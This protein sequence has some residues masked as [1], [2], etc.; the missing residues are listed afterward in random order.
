MSMGHAKPFCENRLEQV[1]PAGVGRSVRVALLKTAAVVV[2]FGTVTGAFEPNLNTRTISDAVAL[3]LTRI[4]QDRNRF[5]RLYRIEV[6]T[7]PVDWVDIITPFRR[8]VLEA[9]TQTQ[10]GSRLFGQR[11]AIEALKPNPEQVDIVVELT[12]HP[13]NRFTRIPAYEVVVAT[14]P[15]ATASTVVPDAIDYVPRFGPRIGA[16]LLPYPYANSTTVSGGGQPILGGV[17][18]ARFTGQRL[19]A[20][21]RY[22][23]VIRDEGQQEL[24]RARV[25]FGR[26]R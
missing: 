7:A 14:I 6:G 2:V 20:N 4:E 25:D 9:E 5:H 13:L 15:G 8:V 11:E 3:G 21:G 23:I 16:S 17:I 26:L 19:A 12:F 1:Y 10:T 18:A 22:D 24:A